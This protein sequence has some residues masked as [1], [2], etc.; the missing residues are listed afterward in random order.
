MTF[1]PTD[2]ALRQLYKQLV[3]DLESRVSALSQ[4]AAISHV[5]H[6]YIDAVATAVRYKSDVAHIQAIQQVIDLCE[7]IDRQAYGATK[8]NEDEE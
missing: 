8:N 7:Q 2:P 1:G 6:G 4:G 3:A 5:D